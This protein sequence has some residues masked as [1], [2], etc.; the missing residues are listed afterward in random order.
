MMDVDEMKECALKMAAMLPQDDDISAA[1]AVGV[2]A[3]AVLSVLPDD[4]F[5][6]WVDRLRTARQKVEDAR[7]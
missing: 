2:L 3:S 1:A 5:N 7:G 6:S 4:C